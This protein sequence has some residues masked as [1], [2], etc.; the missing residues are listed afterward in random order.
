VEGHSKPQ[1]SLAL[2]L[3][4]KKFD[5]ITLSLIHPPPLSMTRSGPS[6]GIRVGLFT[7][8]LNHLKRN[9]HRDVST[10]E[11]VIKNPPI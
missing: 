6:I 2:S 3:I 9:I 5:K 10:A 1:I 7:K 4:K 8:G 11:D